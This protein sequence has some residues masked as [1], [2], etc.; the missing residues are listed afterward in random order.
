MPMFLEAGAVNDFGSTVNTALTT[1]VNPNSLATQFV[2][3]LPWVGLM[4]I[5]AF[6][7]Y[8]VRKLV[9]GASKGKARL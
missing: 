8:E 5:V 6:V 2:Q 4:V 1:S 3:I 9:K 7:L